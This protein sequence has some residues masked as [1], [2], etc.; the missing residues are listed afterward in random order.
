MVSMLLP[1]MI[2]MTAVMFS[3]VIIELKLNIFD[4]FALQG[5]NDVERGKV[6]PLYDI[7][8]SVRRKK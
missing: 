8:S 1:P 7:Q 5:V 6:R 3:F 4:A 2:G